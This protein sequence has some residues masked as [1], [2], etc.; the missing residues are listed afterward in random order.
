MELGFGSG[1]L[2]WKCNCNDLDFLEEDEPVEPEPD[3][4]STDESKLD[5]FTKSTCKCELCEKLNNID[6]T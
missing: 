4:V 2:K 3:N 5:V 1:T 6:R